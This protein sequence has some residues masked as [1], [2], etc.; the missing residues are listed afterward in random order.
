M[1]YLFETHKGLITSRLDI[2][3]ES[4]RDTYSNINTWSADAI[5]RIFEHAKRGKM[6]RGCLFLEV[7]SGLGVEIESGHLDVAVAIELYHTGLLIH[8]DIMDND[9]IRRG[10][11]SVFASYEQDAR[12]A[13]LKNPYHF[14]ISQAIG[15]GDVAF[16]L[17]N[18]L[19]ISA[20]LNNSELSQKISSYLS[21]ELIKVGFAQMDDV[22]SGA[23]SE[24]IST[25]RVMR[26][27][28]YKTARYTL[29]MPIVAAILFSK[30]YISEISQIEAT[31][32][33]LGIL[34]QIKDDELGI[35][36]SE[37]ETGKTVGS[38]IRERKQ[39]IFY[40][41]LHKTGE[42]E[43]IGHLFGNDNLT[44]HDVALVRSFIKNSRANAS[45]ASIVEEFRLRFETGLDSVSSEHIR[46]LLRS[47]YEFN[48]SRHA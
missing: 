43:Q 44:A 9:R 34:F 25:E 7:L 46:L 30:K 26:T 8:D 24:I 20:Q 39:T 1:K 28:R 40:S 27:Y 23:T 41:C 15:V 32:E 33:A 5:D 22:F 14:G 10:V 38:D 6:V 35:F 17:A 16:F 42:Y 48:Q 37:I 11:P 31:T 21:Q 12:D 2:V 3:R 19:V 13:S 29:T 45:V 36:G 47:V 18:N 4:S